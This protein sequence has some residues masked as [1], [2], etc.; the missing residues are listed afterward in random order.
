LAV[1]SQVKVTVYN[2]T[3]EKIA[4]LVNERQT[5]G[6]HS[7]RFDASGLASGVYLYRI[8]AEGFVQTRKMILMR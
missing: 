3:G 2:I 1:G 7:V 6:S 5:A 4:G 8:E